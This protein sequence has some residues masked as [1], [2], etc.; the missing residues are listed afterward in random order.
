MPRF[1]DIAIRSLVLK[2]SAAA[3][4]T[5]GRVILWD[6][7]FTRYYEPHVGMAAVTVLEAAG[8]EVTSWPSANVADG[9][10]SARAT[11]TKPPGWAGTISRC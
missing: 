6:D 10:P 3:P 11:S 5:R 7:T 8:F 2:T 1:A 9:P 4:A